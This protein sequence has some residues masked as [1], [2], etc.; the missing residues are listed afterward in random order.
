LFADPKTVVK[1]VVKLKRIALK[2]FEKL[3]LRS[4]SDARIIL[5]PNFPIN[6]IEPP[7]N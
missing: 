3:L 5:N 1:K 4:G 7:D 2:R 6:L